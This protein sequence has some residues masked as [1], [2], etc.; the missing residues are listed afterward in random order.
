MPINNARRRTSQFWRH[1]ASICREEEAT[2][3]NLAKSPNPM[4]RLTCI[5]CFSFSYLHRGRLRVSPSVSRLNASLLSEVPRRDGGR[6]K[7]L[8][9]QRPSSD[10]AGVSDWL[11]APSDSRAWRP[12]RRPRTEARARQRDDHKGGLDLIG[13]ITEGR[14]LINF[15]QCPLRS[16]SDHFCARAANGAMGQ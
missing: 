15:R 7:P 13:P 5:S 14:V 6:G 10:E 9:A 4:R 12:Q 16:D 2:S 1:T 11:T 8:H 3:S